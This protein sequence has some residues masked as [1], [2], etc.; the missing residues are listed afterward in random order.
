[1]KESQ[2]FV[3]FDGFQRLLK[4]DVHV[5]LFATPPAFRPSHFEAAVDCGKHVFMEKPVATDPPG[6][7]RI[8][9]SNEIAKG[10][11]LSVQ[12]GFKGTINRTIDHS[13]Q[14]FKM[15][16]LATFFLLAPI[17]MGLLLEK[18]AECQIRA[19]WNF[20]WRTGTTSTG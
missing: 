8:L 3:G 19:N 4:C 5:V 11:G 7:R 10:K 15:G 9:K 12:V 1:M 14:R 18:K 6:I 20:N 2:R 17:G 16:V 13:F